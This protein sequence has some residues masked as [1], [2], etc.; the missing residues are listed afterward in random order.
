[1]DKEPAF[2]LKDKYNNI[3]VHIVEKATHQLIFDNPK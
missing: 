2:K 1:M 3:K